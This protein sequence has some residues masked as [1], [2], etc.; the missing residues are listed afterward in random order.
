MGKKM[1]YECKQEK[2]HT[3][4]VKNKRNKDGLNGTCNEC[5]NSYYREYR[6]KNN[7]EYREYCKKRNKTDKAKAYI[8]EWRKTDKAKEIQRKYRSTPEYKNKSH[9]YTTSISYKDRVNKKRWD[10]IAEYRQRELAYSKERRK[11]PEVRIKSALRARLNVILK[12]SNGSKSSK[13]VEIIGCTMPFLRQHLE[14]LWRAGMSWDNYGFG[15]GRWVID[16]VI[17][18]DKFD[19]TDKEQQKVCFNFRNL[20]PLWWEENAI[21]SNK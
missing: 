10:N 16:H 2:D 8:K 13:M 4:F 3:Y 12:R 15:R 1:C 18:C 6:Q 17:S 21:K 9:E 19:L 11:I 5:R 7:E 20:Q 14:F